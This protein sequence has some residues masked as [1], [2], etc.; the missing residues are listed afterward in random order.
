MKWWDLCNQLFTLT[1]KILLFG[2]FNSWLRSQAG[3]KLGI[4]SFNFDCMYI[5]P[6]VRIC[7]L[8]FAVHSLPHIVSHL[9]RKELQSIWSRCACRWIDLKTYC[10]R[11]AVP[12]GEEE[13]IFVTFASSVSSNTNI[14]SCQTQS[15]PLS[16]LSRQ[17]HSCITR[18]IQ[19]ITPIVI[20]PCDY[21][22]GS[23][24][25]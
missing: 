8:V 22:R 5:F 15:S 11:V 9:I 13:S 23:S 24:M 21:L 7:N 18:M 16:L 12:D 17:F 3:N 6:H 1:F 25:M 19:P 20:L 4:F 14:E 2:S 10:S